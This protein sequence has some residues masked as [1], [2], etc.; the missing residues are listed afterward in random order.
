MI[1]YMQF[2]T[3]NALFTY[4]IITCEY[5]FTSPPFF[6]PLTFNFPHPENGLVTTQ[7][8]AHT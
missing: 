3:K 1:F 4:G 7:H 5:Q 6:R 2:I 8:I